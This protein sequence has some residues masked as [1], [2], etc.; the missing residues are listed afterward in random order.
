M[1]GEPPA[2]PAAEPAPETA[3][4]ESGAVDP[5]EATDTDAAETGAEVLG[6]TTETGGA[7]GLDAAE[8]ACGADPC[9]AA[10]PAA[11]PPE[12]GAG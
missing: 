9:P 8:P 10:D 3:P 2:L 5:P 11:A 12:P 1:E 7:D 6:V 4:G